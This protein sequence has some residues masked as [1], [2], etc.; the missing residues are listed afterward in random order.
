[1]PIGCKFFYVFF[2]PE[3]KVG[4]DGQAGNERAAPASVLDAE[5]PLTPHVNYFF[6]TCILLLTF[7]L[8]YDTITL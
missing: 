7:Q 2:A 5:S 6:K 3:E 1:M 8:F 4:A